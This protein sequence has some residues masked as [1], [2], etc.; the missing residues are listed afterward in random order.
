MYSSNQRP[1]WLVLLFLVLVPVPIVWTE[2]V[3]ATVRPVS[4]RSTESPHVTISR[5]EPLGNAPRSSRVLSSFWRFVNSNNCNTNHLTRGLRQPRKLTMVLQ[6]TVTALPC[7]AA[8][9]FRCREK[10]GSQPATAGS[11]NKQNR[12]RLSPP[13]LNVYGLA[14]Q[15]QNS[16]QFRE[17]HAIHRQS[18]ESHAIRAT[19]NEIEL[20]G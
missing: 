16:D 11:G 15:F 7:M 14:I 2:H 5:F 10:W 3:A 9:T 4:P 17:S 18:R 20:C 6:L 8:S 19:T 1:L 13:R 12:L